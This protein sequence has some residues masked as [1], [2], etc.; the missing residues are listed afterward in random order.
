[1]PA[2]YLW[3]LTAL[4]AMLLSFSAGSFA[5]DPASGTTSLNGTIVDATGAVVL[6]ATVKIHNPVSGLDRSVQTDT[7]GGFTFPN[8]PFNP[9]HLTVTARAAGKQTTFDVIARLDNEVEVQYYRDGGVLPYVF[10]KLTT[11]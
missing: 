9:Y 6:G 2:S 4:A 1:M 7:T 5:G 11:T 10:G 3:R 8:V